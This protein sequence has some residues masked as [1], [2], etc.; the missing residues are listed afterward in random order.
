MAAFVA[1]FGYT[2]TTPNLLHFGLKL[3]FRRLSEGV[4]KG[5]G[6]PLTIKNQNMQLNQKTSITGKTHNG[7]KHLSV[8]FPRYTYIMI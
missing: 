6:Q 7:Q 4:G 1:R 2:I 5:F 8:R 3:L